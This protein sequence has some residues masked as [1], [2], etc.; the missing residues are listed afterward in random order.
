M[1]KIALLAITTILVGC[2]ATA[3]N[4]SQTP[5]KAA[6]ETPTI[7]ILSIDELRATLRDLNVAVQDLDQVGFPKRGTVPPASSYRVS[8]LSDS[9]MNSG[10]I[11]PTDLGNGKTKWVRTTQKAGEGNQ[12]VEDIESTLVLGPGEH[13]ITRT[14]VVKASETRPLGTYLTE[15]IAPPESGEIGSRH[16]E[17]QTTYTSADQSISRSYTLT[18]DH[19]RTSNTDTSNSAKLVGELASGTNVDLKT[20]FHNYDSTFSGTVT[21]RSGKKIALSLS[22]E[23]SYIRQG[24]VSI[25]TG[26][27]LVGLS[28]SEDFKMAMTVASTT[29]SPIGPS[30]GAAT[31]DITIDGK[32]V[33]RNESQI[34]K[35]SMG[36]IPELISKLPTIFITY[37][38]K[39][40]EEFDPGFEVLFGKLYGLSGV[41]VF[42]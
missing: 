34:A 25:S 16:S 9:L 4:T 37:E 24:D 33:D 15:G 11:G 20:S 39:Q 2:T 26:R 42:N 28:L 23:N 7:T 21:L 32:V 17:L 3:P 18:A 41:N 38:G 1:K 6:D 13:Q 5:Q 31:R 8:A 19:N 29:S 36:P 30:S 27:S 12:L 35:I 14:D 40:A 10:W 22:A